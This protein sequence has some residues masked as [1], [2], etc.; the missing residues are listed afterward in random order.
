MGKVI[1]ISY[2]PMRR[3][4]KSP[5][6]MRHPNPARLIGSDVAPIIQIDSQTA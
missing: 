5:I 3:C 1:E 2:Y 6:D 4:G